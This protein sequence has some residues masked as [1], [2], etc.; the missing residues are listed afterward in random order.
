MVMRSFRIS[1]LIVPM[2][3]KVAVMKLKEQ[4]QKRYGHVL[5]LRIRNKKLYV[6][7]E[8]LGNYRVRNWILDQA[9]AA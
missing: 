5:V 3:S 1:W 4:V 7:G 2:K 9:E 6:T 8:G